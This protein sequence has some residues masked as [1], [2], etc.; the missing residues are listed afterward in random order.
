WMAPRNIP[1]GANWG[2]AIIDG[3]NDSSAI[4]LVLSTHSNKSEQV[5]REIERAASKR[6]PIITL[7]LDD[8]APSKSLEFYLSMS[9]WLDAQ[10][11]GRAEPIK[12]L[13]QRVRE[14][15]RIDSRKQNLR[16]V[17]DTA[18]L[19]DSRDERVAPSARKRSKNKTQ[20]AVALGGVFLLV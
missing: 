8:L 1:P 19:P 11:S 3:I 7:R 2:E 9:Q 10:M 4:V 18:L 20:A 17:P 12:Q 14:L 5:Q 13:T 16:T 15:I 6:I